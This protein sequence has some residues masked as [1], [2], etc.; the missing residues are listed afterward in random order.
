MCGGRGNETKA[1][2]EE[3]FWKFYS[4]VRL[5]KTKYGILRGGFIIER[6]FQDIL[7]VRMLAQ[8]S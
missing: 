8:G 2:A 4:E 3:I 6:G 5:G 7:W 1:R